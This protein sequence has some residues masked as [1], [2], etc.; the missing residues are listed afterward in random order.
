MT[1]HTLD[2]TIDFFSFVASQHKNNDP[3]MKDKK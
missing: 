2:E 1:D 3:N